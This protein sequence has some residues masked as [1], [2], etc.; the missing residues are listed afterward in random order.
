MGERTR[1]VVQPP[2]LSTC[3]VL[4]NPRFIDTDIIHVN[5][6]GTSIIVLDTAEAVTELFERRSSQYS[7]RLV[8]LCFAKILVTN[9]PFIELECL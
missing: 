9:H 3:G 6:A 2:W 7:N 8:D 4:I 5:V 1:C